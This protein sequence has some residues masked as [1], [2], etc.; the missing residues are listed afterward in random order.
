MEYDYEP[1]YCF[2]L[3]SLHYSDHCFVMNDRIYGRV[4]YIGTGLHGS[5][6]IAFLFCWSVDLNVVLDLIRG[7]KYSLIGGLR[8]CAQILIDV[9]RVP[10]GFSECERE[11]LRRFNVEYSK[12]STNKVKLFDRQMN[13]FKQMFTRTE[14]KIRSTTKHINSAPRKIARNAE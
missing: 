8:V 4:F 6:A 5:H 11:L 10:F 3:V 14:L 12:M 13:L 1:Q 7:G 2:R 9:H